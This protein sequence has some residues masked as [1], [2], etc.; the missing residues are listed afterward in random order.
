MLG[1]SVPQEPDSKDSGAE[2]PKLR[3]PGIARFPRALLNQIQFVTACERYF[4]W[5]A[6]HKQGPR[7]TSRSTDK[8]GARLDAGSIS[9][10][11][12]A[13]IKFRAVVFW[14]HLLFTATAE[15]QAKQIL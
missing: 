8:N 11:A 15:W 7:F 14:P 13:L 2:L 10:K 9:K 3:F 5:K 4:P 6:C 1:E 12:T